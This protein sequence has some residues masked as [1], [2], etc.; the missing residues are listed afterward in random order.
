MSDGP[1]AYVPALGFRSLTRFYDPILRLTL[2]ED[3]FKTLLVQQA[4]VHAGQRVLDL[5]CGTATLTIMLKQACP[6]AVIVGLDADPDALE[7][8]R[9]KVSEA[10]VE[11]ELREGTAF[12]PPFGAKSFDRVVSSLVFHHLSTEQ[13]PGSRARSGP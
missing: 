5:G 2:R 9:K 1:K 4:A 3:K 13:A 12:E 8:A 11:V 7:I 10:G 6:G